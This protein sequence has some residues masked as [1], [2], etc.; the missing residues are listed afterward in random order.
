MKT[1][2]SRP[3]RK[4]SARHS[5][6]ALFT[7]ACP[8]TLQAE[9]ETTKSFSSA[10]LGRKMALHVAARTDSHRISPNS[11]L[12]LLPVPIWALKRSCKRDTRAER[13]SIPRRTTCKH[14]RDYVLAY[15]PLPPVLANTCEQHRL[16]RQKGPIP[17]LLLALLKAAQI[18]TTLPWL[19][20][21][22]QESS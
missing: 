17:L 13:I 19:L 8:P 7:P 1:G 14:R 5:P 3:L 2:A 4:L 6:S 9:P 21:D 22:K 11:H 12:D 18:H 20:T 15:N 10:L 16:S